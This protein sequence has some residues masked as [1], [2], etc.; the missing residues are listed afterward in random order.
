MDA[1]WIEILDGADDDAVVLAVAH[2]L[3]FELLPAEERFIDKDFGNWREIQ[4]PGDDLFIL[5]TVVSYASALS[6]EGESGADDERK[7]SNFLGDFS[8]LLHR[9]GDTGAWHVEPDFLHGL[10]E[11]VAVLAFVDGCGVGTDH[12]D[13]V[14]LERPGFKQRHGGV[15]RGLPAEGRK[16]SVGP[17]PDDDLLDDLGGDRLDVGPV[18]ELRIGHDGRWVRIHQNDLVTLFFKSLARLYPRVVEFAS[19]ADDNWAGADD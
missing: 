3:H 15:E 7:G 6:A 2:D 14:L 4:A 1:H 8:R 10:F 12:A 11:K 13:S 19:L 18:G 9:A 5:L 17:F 16:Q